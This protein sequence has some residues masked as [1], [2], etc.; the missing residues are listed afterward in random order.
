MRSSRAPLLVGID[1]GHSLTKVVVADPSGRTMGMA[2]RGTTISSP[3]PGW[4]ERDMTTFWTDVTSAIRAAT[5]QAGAAREQIA[6]VGISGHSDGLYLVDAGLRPVRPAIL[7]ADA[8]AAGIAEEFWTGDSADALLE[9]TGRLPFAPSPAALIR[10][11]AR[12]EPATLNAARWALFCKDWVRLRLTG[13]V[14]TDVTD[15][16]ASF[17]D[18]RT[19]TWSRDAIDLLGCSEWAGL[20][21]PILPSAAV[22]G[23]VTESA[24]RETGLSPGT[25]VVTG[26][27][28][29][30]AAAIG[31][32]AV[33]PEAGS[34]V[35][36]TYCIAQVVQDA[37][38]TGRWWQARSFADPARWLHMS[39]SAS[40][41]ANVDWAA[42][43]T[44]L[45]T[46]VEAT[47]ERAL[48]TVVGR[49]DPLFLAFVHGGPYRT[50]PMTRFAE[51]H[52]SASA[53]DLMR[54]VVEG[55]CHNCRAH[56]DFLTDVLP[57]QPALRI[58]GGA[59][60][61]A[62][63]MR[64]LADVLN[65]PVEV[66]SSTEASAV[67][68]ALLAGV[69]TGLL[70]G[71][72]DA[73]RAITVKRVFEPD[74]ARTDLLAERHR[75]WLAALSRAVHPDRRRSRDSAV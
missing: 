3:V 12:E 1:C 38:H 42:R 75:A 28:D 67:G 55:I 2:S 63:W 51:G 11:L 39:T 66:T 10:W 22:A 24:A 70:P 13:E 14:A 9:L 53:D 59:A 19:H 40:G 49:A 32:G 54:A 69:G 58:S 26:V 62:P 48:S 20:L 27:H 61:S 15:S 17:A 68:A 60:R 41:T 21:P 56:L 72:D 73:A 36:G 44:G 35:L 71:I 65:R 52:V 43:Q 23:T 5:A 50:P 7:A 74:P 31:I 57:I 33:A 37:P 4:H 6:G 45:T 29:V 25:P 8:R 18:I 30:D 16:G 47:I 46:G 34:V 64:L